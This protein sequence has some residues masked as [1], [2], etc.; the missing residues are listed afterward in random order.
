[1]KKKIIST[2][3]LLSFLITG[4]ASTTLINSEPSGATL[5]MNG[6][7]VGKTPY[8]HTDSKIVGASTSLK[9]KKKGYEDLYVVLSKDE[10]V[11]IGAIIGG[12][13]VIVPFLW[14]MKYYP[15]HNYE[16]EEES[17]EK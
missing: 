11:N 14:T 12:F 4:C 13:F 6:M 8:T 1:M 3:I 7:K 10:D 16:L 2:L 15:V 5:Y 9:M 17:K